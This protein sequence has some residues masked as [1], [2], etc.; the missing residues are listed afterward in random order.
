MIGQVHEAVHQVRL[1]HV[2]GKGTEFLVGGQAA[3]PRG[4][5]H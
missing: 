4:L 2:C 5:P 3:T 1:P